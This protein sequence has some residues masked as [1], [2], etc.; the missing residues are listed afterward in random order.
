MKTKLLF[1]VAIFLLSANSHL[2]AQ[3]TVHSTTIGG[4]WNEAST[5]I[6]NEVVMNHLSDDY[7]GCC[8]A[9]YA[10]DGN[11]YYGGSL[12]P[13]DP[14]NGNLEM[15]A[16]YWPQ[17]KSAEFL[18]SGNRITALGGKDSKLYFIVEGVSDKSYPVCWDGTN[19]IDLVGPTDIAK[20]EILCS[21]I[22]RFTN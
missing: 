20:A 21:A 3:Q 13:D 18:T 5:W 22:A 10:S 11:V 12:D 14:N 17:G 1:I 19:W 7:D 8:F 16:C 6:E 2:R 4:W 9:V 15:T